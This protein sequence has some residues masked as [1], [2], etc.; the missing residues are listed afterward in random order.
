MMAE[1]KPERLTKVFVLN[2]GW[3]KKTGIG[4]WL[5]IPGKQP[6][7]KIIFSYIPQLMLNLVNITLDLE[8]EFY[9]NAIDLT[10]RV[11]H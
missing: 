2:L 1:A 6:W 5:N 10:H 4:L 3:V 7:S 11:F 8:L 9:L